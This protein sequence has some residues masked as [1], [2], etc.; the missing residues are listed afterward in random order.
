MQ[1]IEPY[2]TRISDKRLWWNAAHKNDTYFLSQFEKL[3]NLQE[4]LL[5]LHILLFSLRNW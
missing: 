3:T 1:Y 4:K 5:E 2:P